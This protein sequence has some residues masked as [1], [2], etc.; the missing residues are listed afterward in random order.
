MIYNHVC[1]FS[2]FTKF[3]IKIVPSHHYI[4]LIHVTTFIDENL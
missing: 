1:N 4:L 2:A 3:E